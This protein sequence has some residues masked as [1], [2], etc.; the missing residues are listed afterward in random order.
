[1]AG[2]KTQ[3]GQVMVLVAVSLLAL[4]GSAALVLLAGSAEWQKNQLQQLADQAA[5]DSALK[6]GVGCDAGKATTI[7][8][9]PTTS[10]RRSGRG[11]V[12]STS[13]AAHVPHRTQAPTLSPE[14]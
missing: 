1:M 6:I 3:S 7:I 14:G 4:I 10:S 8:T 12:R 11:P 13:P 2:R 5:L 9:G